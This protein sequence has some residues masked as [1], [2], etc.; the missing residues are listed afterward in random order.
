MV[1][2]PDVYEPAAEETVTE[3]VVRALADSKDLDPAGMDER[4]YDAVDPDALD[5]LFDSTAD[6]T[7]CRVA[8]EFADRR[9]VV[10]GSRTVYVTTG[11]DRSDESTGETPQVLRGA[12]A[13]WRLVSR[14]P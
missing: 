1:E 10:D 11:P 9:V 13:P 4:L 14:D 2:S 6:A 12:A 5:R 7:G 8:F 3:T